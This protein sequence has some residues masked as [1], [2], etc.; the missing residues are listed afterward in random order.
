M[1]IHLDRHYRPCAGDPGSKSA[2]PHGIGMA[3]TRPAMTEGYGKRQTLRMGTEIDDP[4]SYAAFFSAMRTRLRRIVVE[5]LMRS[6]GVSTSRM[7]TIFMSG[8]TFAKE[9]C[10]V[11]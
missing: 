3:G 1:E 8:R 7:K 11:T 2:A 10:S 4:A 6:S 9:A 5:A